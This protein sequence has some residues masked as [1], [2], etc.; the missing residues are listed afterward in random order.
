MKKDSALVVF[1]G[2]QDS[3]TC[4]YWALN[5]F[6]PVRAITFDYGQKHKIELQSAA[7]LCQKENIQQDV[8]SVSSLQALGGNALVDNEIEISDAHGNNNLPNT[9]VPGRNIVFLSL[10]AAKAYQL[11]INHLV[12]GVGQADYSGYPDCREDFIKSLEKTLQLGMEFKLSIHRPLM[13]KDKAEIWELS[14]QLGHLQDIIQHTHTCYK[15]EH[16]QLHSWGYGCG[17]CPACILRKAGFKKYT[18][19]KIG[20]SAK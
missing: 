11:G 1:S 7:E 16:D 20:L 4:L 10:A 17:E 14:D 8:I 9:F 5:K 15:G 18:E 13:F 12:T 2:G 3:T 6:S 19:K